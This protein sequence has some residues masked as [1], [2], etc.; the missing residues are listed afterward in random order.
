MGLG[1]Y[2]SLGEYCGPHTASSGFLILIYVWPEISLMIGNMSSNLGNELV[3]CVPII[4][5]CDCTHNKNEVPSLLSITY[6]AIHP[7]PRKETELSATV[8]ANLIEQPSG[9]SKICTVPHYTSL[10]L[11][12][13]S[14]LQCRQTVG[15]T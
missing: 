13:H 6:N 15:S 12:L 4:N 9:T 2:N 8:Q 1:Q 11:G 14:V 7:W 3:Q 5:S 10:L